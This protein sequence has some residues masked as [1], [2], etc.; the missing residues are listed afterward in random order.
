MDVIIQSYEQHNLCF[1][2]DPKKF[3]KVINP[4]SG[5]ANLPGTVV[6]LGQQSAKN[7]SVIPEEVFELLK[8]DEQFSQL[9][10]RHIIIQREKLPDDFFSAQQIVATAKGETEK[11][12]AEVGKLKEVLEKKEKEIALLKNKIE[13]ARL[14]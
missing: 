6:L 12:K 9:F 1:R 10:E 4:V 14:E 2:V 11:A 8:Q 13:N 7:I 5:K 3:N